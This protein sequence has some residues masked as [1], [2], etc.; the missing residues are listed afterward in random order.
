M[1]KLIMEQ[2]SPISPELTTY[3]KSW[4]AAY[5]QDPSTDPIRAEAVG[6]SM[7][8]LTYDDFEYIGRLMGNVDVNA[9][10]ANSDARFELLQ[11]V[12]TTIVERS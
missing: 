6:M 9:I 4:L 11:K 7:G 2:S 5:E 8:V 1:I 10:N 3:A 12:M